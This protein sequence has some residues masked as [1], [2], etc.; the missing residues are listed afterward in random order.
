MEV[1]FISG[2]IY[3]SVSPAFPTLNQWKSGEK[4]TVANNSI[5]NFCHM[6]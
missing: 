5:T 2:I 4:A 1:S 3:F 6:M